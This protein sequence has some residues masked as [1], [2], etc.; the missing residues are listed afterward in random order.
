MGLRAALIACPAWANWAPNPAILLLAAQLRHAGHEIELFDLNIDAFR[1]VSSEYQSWWESSNSRSWETD[2][3]VE[4]LWQEHLAFFHDYAYQILST[5]PD[6]IAFTINSGAKCTTP[7]FARL[8]RSMSPHIPIIVGGPDCFRSEAFTQHLYPGVVNA[9]C[10]G[11]GDFAIVNLLSALE[12]KGFIPEDLRGFVIPTAEGFRDN[13]DPDRP[14]NLDD[15]KPIDLEGIDLARY[16]LTNRVTLSLS[17]GCVK[18][19]S[20]CSEGPNF[21]KYRTHSAKWIIDQLETLVPQIEEQSA[22][23]MPHI[24]FNDSLIN[25]DMSVLGAICDYFIE[26]KLRFTWGGMAIIRPEMTVEFMS[27]MREAGCVEICWGIESGSTRILELMRKGI[28]VSLIDQA[29]REGAMAGI[30][31]YGNIIV[32]FPGETPFDFAETLLF[33]AK[34]VSFFSCLGLPVYIPTKNSLVYK[35]PHKFGLASLDYLSWV[36]D[37]GLNTPEVRMFRRKLLS[38]ILEERLFDQGLGKVVRKHYQFESLTPEIQR[39]FLAIQNAAVQV[40]GEYI[41]LCP[42]LNVQLPEKLPPD[43]DINTPN[44]QKAALDAFDDFVHSLSM[45]LR[46]RRMTLP[47]LIDRYAD[48]AKPRAPRG[49]LQIITGDDPLPQVV[50]TKDGGWM[51][52]GGEHVGGRGSCE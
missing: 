51:T 32:G 17:R 16:T 42:E 39:E 41:A 7:R 23:Q 24:N 30:N 4:R 21:F 12:A 26:R 50:D 37:D 15:V 52:V 35:V 2:E 31:Q 40:A 11:E 45:Q 27:K 43:Y 49:R 33:T 47:L 10:P 20:F 46:E 13:G 38:D 18:R 44:K 6:V 36:T 8:I 1:A 28:S 29:L 14:A 48:N 34:N 5:N 22:G 19:C 25:G 9:L 3:E